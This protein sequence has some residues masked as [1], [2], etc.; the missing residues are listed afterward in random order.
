MD[1]R[2]AEF[3]VVRVNNQQYRVGELLLPSHVAGGTD[4]KAATLRVQSQDTHNKQHGVRDLVLRLPHFAL[5]T[6]TT[7]TPTLYRHCAPDF[8][9]P[10]S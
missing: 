9:L 1:D 7:D 8:A 5:S 3:L 4:D 6:A 2:A 10:L